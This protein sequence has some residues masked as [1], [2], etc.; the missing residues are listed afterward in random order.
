MLAEALTRPTDAAA[1]A[2]PTSAVA[3]AD[4]DE[5]MF[6]CKFAGVA[7][8]SSSDCS[9]AFAVSLFLSLLALV[10]SVRV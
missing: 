10:C 4:D 3:A 2:T 5:T 6:A 7:A 8:S 9:F 1:D